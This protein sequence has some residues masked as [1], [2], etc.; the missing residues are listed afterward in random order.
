MQLARA[1]TIN[2]TKLSKNARARHEEC[3]SLLETDDEE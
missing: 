3:L 1:R 2:S